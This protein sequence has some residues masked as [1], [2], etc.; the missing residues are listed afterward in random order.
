MSERVTTFTVLKIVFVSQ[1]LFFGVSFTGVVH[2]QEY[3]VGPADTLRRGHSTC[4]PEL[5]LPVDRMLGWSGGGGKANPESGQALP[6]PKVDLNGNFPIMLLRYRS[7]WGSGPL[8]FLG[9][10]N[11]PPE[12]ISGWVL[13]GWVLARLAPTP[14]QSSA[15]LFVCFWVEVIAKFLRDTTGR[16]FCMSFC[17]NVPRR[18]GKF[19]K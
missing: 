2:S 1:A 18:R 4:S 11:P 12:R 3:A 6:F 5:T 9:T 10:S 7:L 16:C 17:A 19:D 13:S 15:F 8:R 14:V